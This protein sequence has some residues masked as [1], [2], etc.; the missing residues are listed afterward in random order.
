MISLAPPLGLQNPATC[1]AKIKAAECSDSSN[2]GSAA[3]KGTVCAVCSHLQVLAVSCFHSSL[4]ILI[5]LLRASLAHSTPREHLGVR[6]LQRRE[7]LPASCCHYRGTACKFAE[8]VDLVYPTVSNWSLN[9]LIITQR[10]TP[11]NLD[12]IRPPLMM[13]DLSCSFRSVRLRVQGLSALCQSLLT[14]LFFFTA[15]PG[16]G[17]HTKN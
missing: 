3:V 11:D 12:R 6:S 16:S 5:L 1:G 17:Q 2:F 15:A 4:E 8:A 13:N 7:V 9:M 14:R 10:H